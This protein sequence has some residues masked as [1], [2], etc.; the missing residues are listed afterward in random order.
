M[1]MR[2][3]CVLAAALCCVLGMVA[4]AADTGV[5]GTWNT[6]GVAA[7]QAA[8]KAKKSTN[9]LPDAT[10]IKFK[11]DT[12]KGKVSGTVTA[13][14]LDKEFEVVDGKIEGNTF[15]FG[16]IPATSIGFG[17]NNGGNFN[18]NNNNRNQNQNQNQPKPILWKG[19][20]KDADT[21]SLQRV[22]DSGNPMKT[23]DGAVMGAVTFHRAKK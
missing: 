2:F 11:V 14:N 22:D 4:I 12:K 3:K 7:F 9:G 16:A 1:K 8:V 5:E 21:I 18:N 23:A 13:F 20:L 19:E 10:Q 17:N 6:E 15:T